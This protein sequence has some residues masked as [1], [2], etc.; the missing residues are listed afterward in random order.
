MAE[1]ERSGEGLPKVYDPGVVEEK[2]YRFWEENELF[3]ATM[4]PERQNFCIVIPP[5]NVTGSLHMGHAMQHT[6]H[7]VLVRWRRMQGYNTLWLPGTDHAGIA[8]QIKV[9]ERLR[10]EEGLTRHD[11]GREKFLEQ[12][13]AWKEHYN[14]NITSQMKKLGDS[15]DWSRHRFTM[16]EGLSKA[17]REAFIRLYE[18]GLIYQDSYIVNWC[19]HCHTT[20]SDLEVEHE[21]DPGHLWYIKYPYTGG[22]GY[23]VVATTRPETMLGDTAVAVHPEDGRYRG[24]IGKTVILPLMNRE[25]PVV[26]DEFVD[27]AFGTGMVKVTPAHDPNDFEIGRRHQLPQVAVI[28][29]DG[30][31]TREAGAYAGLPVLECR[32]KV[33]ADLE[34]LGLLVKTEEH[35][36]AVGH[37]YRCGE[38][39]EPLVSKQWFVRMKPLAEPAIKAVRDGDIRFVPDRFTKNYLYWMENIRDW[40]I[41][42]QLWWGHRI[43]VWTCR[44]CGEQFALREDPESC[45]KCRGP[46]EGLEQDPDVLDTWF[47]SALWPFSTMGWPEETADLAFW[48]PTTV[49]ITAYDIIY[50][51]VARMIFSGL[52]F[53]GKK[54]FSD[55]L[56]HGLVRDALGRKMSR[57]RGTGVDP[58]ELV[59]EYGADALRFTLVTGVAPGNDTRYHPERVEASRNFANKI[60]NAS[61]FAL[62]NLADFTPPAA[63]E[64]V[65]GKWRFELVDRWILTRFHQVAQEVT[66]YLER[67]EVGEGAQT[68][69]DFI[70]S[71]LCDWYIEMIK[72]RLYGRMG[73]ESRQAA[74]ATLFYVLRHTLELLHPYMPFITEEIWQHLPTEGLS[75]MLAP[76]PAESP[77]AEGWPAD[78]EEAV[79][80]T[81]M[82]M[83]VV[84]A[85]RNIRAEKAVPPQ[86]QIRAVVHADDQR[87]QVLKENAEMIS[88]LARLASLTVE[89]ETSAPP[90]KALA[91]VAGGVEIF[92]PLADLVDIEEELA[93]LRQEQAET[94]AQLEKVRQRLANKSF[95]EKAP[96]KVVAG[97]R[98]QLAA[99][100]EKREKLAARLAELEG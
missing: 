20:L 7:D 77:A 80:Y 99:L 73:E 54:P 18:K 27:P 36:H 68:I 5:P 66:R 71:E 35:V 79:Q 19:P 39:V 60:W 57:S 64:A 43:P 11:L 26:G 53:T 31:M 40:C 45:P 97:A 81:G 100:E 42:R 32:R 51:W 89:E 82:I 1:M 49:L 16:D 52:E 22:D 88:F 74:Q 21:E 70:W 2:W 85:V 78:D 67:Y 10:K 4:D 37:C 93:R 38:V 29:E 84:R 30:C 95:L 55:I 8:T 12:V 58:L 28:G 83:E 62:M 72:P 48:Y 91:A 33:V 3:K 76:W 65:S 94:E 75:I 14:Q 87:G 69:Y 59:S 47:S 56:V 98:Q 17:V 24:M 34:A 96:E 25:I 13:W 41:S 86:R 44:S 61:R 50:F 23:A 92:L 15:C 90:E 9:E 46:K 6:L 63:G